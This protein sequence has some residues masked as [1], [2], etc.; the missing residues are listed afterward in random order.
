MIPSYA[1]EYI[2]LAI[3]YIRTV[4]LLAKTSGADPKDVVNH[5]I[6]YQG[7]K[8]GG[9]MKY[10]SDHSFSNGLIKCPAIVIR[11]SSFKIMIGGLS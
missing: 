4:Q 2:S 8:N 10:N 11:A 1:T 9:N 7:N 6:R 5:P 3:C